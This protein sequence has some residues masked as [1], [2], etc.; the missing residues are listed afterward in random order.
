[1]DRLAA[2]VRVAY[3]V[4]SR[5]CQLRECICF[6]VLICRETYLSQANKASGVSLWSCNLC[7]V[8]LPLLPS[9][10]TIRQTFP[11]SPTI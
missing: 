11:Y 9:E 2:K 4:F 3:C 10:K 1:M 6:L 8:H 5:T 7:I